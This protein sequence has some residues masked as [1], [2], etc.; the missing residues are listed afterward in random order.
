MPDG[1]TPPRRARNSR[2]AALVGVALGFVIATALL[3]FAPKGE[4]PRA[5]SS[6][7]RSVPAIPGAI[8]PED[9][10]ALGEVLVHYVP[11]LEPLIADTY[12]DFL[13]ALDP[14]VRIV[15][16]V[17]RGAAGSVVGFFDRIDP[18]LA[19]RTRVVEVE[20]PITVW[21]K[22][23]ALVLAPFA[24]QPKTS[25][26]IPVPPDPKW[27]ERTHD[28]ATLAG[29]ASAAPDRYVVREIPLDF[30][31]G[32]FAV[33]RDRVLYDV[34]LLEK[35][36]GR[37]LDTKE[38]LAALVKQLFARDVVMLGSALGDVPRHH[39]SMY[40]T[41]LGRDASGRSIALVG[42]PRAAIDV[43]GRD[44]T[45]GPI[46]PDTGEPLR[47]DFTEATIARFDRAAS[48]LAAAGFA[49][50]RVPVVP[51]D[52]KTYITYTNGVYETSG[53][54]PTSARHVYL[55]QYG[56][57]RLDAIAREKYA[58]LGWI[59]TPVRVSAPW[60]YHGTIGC[61]VNVLARAASRDP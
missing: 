36:K 55:P 10:G 9:E 59:V 42:D 39:M 54:A 11:S 28:W 3:R 58:S 40:M 56:I 1:P 8:L 30:D 43:V 16:V 5:E 61:L 31:A 29:V 24:T 57:A 20:G 41:P 15:A 51:F 53:P 7:L 38:K 21:S 49:V 46:S 33:V 17:P 44:F 2:A 52:D 14:S 12:R 35:N 45:P 32:D 60:P 47:A 18:K 34:N 26:V 13:S 6:A 48:D 23:R 22:D 50:E 37:G 4:S 27:V 19:P 25:L